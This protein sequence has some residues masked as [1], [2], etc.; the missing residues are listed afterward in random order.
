MM[1]KMA[2]LGGFPRGPVVRTSP[3]NAGGAGSIP[4]QGANIPHASLWPKKP[5]HT[6]QK[7]CDNKFNKDYLKKKERKKMVAPYCQWYLKR[8]KLGF[9]SLFLVFWELKHP[10]IHTPIN[11]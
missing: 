5:K 9:S 10:Y 8:A 1:L 6:Q 3:S 7:Q 11:T 2:E 4:S